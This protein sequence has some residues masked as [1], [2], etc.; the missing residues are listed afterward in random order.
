MPSIPLPSLIPYAL[1]LALPASDTAIADLE[2]EVGWLLP[3]PYVEFLKL[4]NG[5]AFE[6]EGA[7][8]DLWPAQEVVALNRDYKIREF[9]GSQ[10][11]AIG[12]DGGGEGILLSQNPNI[13]VGLLGIPFGDLAPSSYRILPHIRL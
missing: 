4:S 1:Q 9:L 12:S 2:R 8:L 13:G 7:Y 5:G 10:V 11:L 3:K 6:V